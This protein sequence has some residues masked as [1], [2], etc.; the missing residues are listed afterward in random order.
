MYTVHGMALSGNCY[1]LKLA[2]EQLGLPY[3]WQELDVRDGSTRTP[4][5]LAKNPN[6]KVPVLELP[7]GSFLSESNAIL[8]YLADGS[9]LWPRER[10]QS[11][12]VMQWL[13]FEQYSH[14]PY[15]ATVRFWL[16]FTDRAEALAEEIAKRRV[17]G[18]RALDVMEQRL[19]DHDYL[20][21]DRYTI[22]DIALYA[23]THVA[24]EG[25]F[26]LADYPAVRAWLTRVAAMPGHVPLG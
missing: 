2:L 12:E 13:F 20:A 18:Y 22:A 8:S 21:A 9:E 26:S 16:R 4:N 3:R 24:E 6:G 1:K 17:Q 14:E 10:R 19:R 15:I 7:D 5:F 11:A 25:G 23:Y